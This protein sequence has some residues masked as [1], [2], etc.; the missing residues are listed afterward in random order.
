MQDRT[1]TPH[2]APDLLGRL[3]NSTAGQLAHLSEMDDYEISDGEPDIKGWDVRTMTGEKVGKV[4]DLIVDTATMKVRYIEVAFDKLLMAS[5]ERRHALIPIGSSR[6][7]GDADDVLVNLRDEQLITLP[8]Y[9]RGVLTRDYETE[10]LHGFERAE[11][12]PVHGDDAGNFYSDEY[13]DEGRA[14][15]RRRA[16]ERRD[17]AYLRRL[18][19]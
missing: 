19:R 3:D 17:D 18:D 6:L 16:A 4:A 10:L 7:D 13:F 15:E 9:V 1:H 11:T 5:G 14:F 8:A 12:L 2:Q